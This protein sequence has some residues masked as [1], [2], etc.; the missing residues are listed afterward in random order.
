MPDADLFRPAEVNILQGD[1]SKARQKLGWGHRIGFEALVQE[2]VEADCRALGVEP[3]A[4]ASA[5]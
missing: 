5:G 1:A 2:M 4:R 3:K